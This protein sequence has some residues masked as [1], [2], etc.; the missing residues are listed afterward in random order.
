[1]RKSI[2][3]PPPNPQKVKQASCFLFP[4]YDWLIKVWPNLV[5]R[6]A[7]Y[8]GCPMLYKSG[9][10]SLRRAACGLPCTGPLSCNAFGCRARLRFR[11]PF[12][13]ARYPR[14]AAAVE[15]LDVCSC[16][17]DDVGDTITVDFTVARPVSAAPGPIAG[18][19]MPGLI[20]ASGGLLVWWR[21]KRKAAAV[22]ATN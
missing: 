21:R 16:V 15:S 5:H 11:Y 10:I 14:I 9:D 13:T 1:M 20:F 6:G 3:D 8:F 12:F 4:S 17:L 2:I 7:A 22:A 18:A 19:G